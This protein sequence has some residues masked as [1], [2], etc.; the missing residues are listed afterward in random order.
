VDWFEVHRSRFEAHLNT[1][2]EQASLPPMG[3]LRLTVL[4]WA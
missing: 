1:L 3:E 4:D 2:R